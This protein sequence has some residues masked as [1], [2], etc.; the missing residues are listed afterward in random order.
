M[1]PRR[2]GLRERS[3]PICTL[4][5]NGYGVGKGQR[6]VS[7]RLSRAA[8]L[9]RLACGGEGVWGAS[10]RAL[11]MRAPDL[12]HGTDEARVAPPRE[13]SSDEA[14]RCGGR[15]EAGRAER[16]RSCPSRRRRKRSCSG[17]GGG[18]GVF[19]RVGHAPASRFFCSVRA[20]AA[21]AYTA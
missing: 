5:Q 12:R 9:R 6:Y 14:T 8:E 16:A 18:C 19:L 15:N 17:D 11:R 7:L 10:A 3:S 21:P 2:K 1:L 20:R 4:S 13:A